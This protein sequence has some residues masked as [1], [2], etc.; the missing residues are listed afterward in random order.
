MKTK[1][2]IYMGLFAAALIFAVAF[3][4][5]GYAKENDDFVIKNG[6]LTDYVGTESKITIPTSV[7][8]IGMRAFSDNS[9]IE[10]VIIPGGVK[11]ID[12]YAFLRCQ[13]LKTVTMKSGVETIEVEAFSGDVNL[14]KVTIPKTVAR[15]KAGNFQD[16]KWLKND[17]R[18]FMIEGIGILIHYSGKS[19]KVTLPS[20]VKGI[21]SDAFSGVKDKLTQVVMNRGLKKISDYAFYGYSK[22]KTVSIPSSVNY[23][24]LD[25]F[26]NTPWLKNNKKEFLV[27]G[28]GILLEYIGSRT[29]AVL[30]TNIKTIY[31][32]AFSN[33]KKLTEVVLNKNLTEIKDAAFFNCKNLKKIN[34]PS[35]VKTIGIDAFS[36]TG[37][38]SVNIPS[39]TTTL[40][41]YAFSYCKNLTQ[42]SF[43]K[44]S[45]LAVIERGLF[46]G[47]ESLN[48]VV[49]PSK[50]TELGEEAFSY[51]T[52]LQSVNLPVTLTKLGDKVFWGDKSLTSI[53][54][55]DK[56]I[57]IPSYLFEDCS[58]LVKVSLSDKITTIGYS[59]F[60]NCGKLSDFTLPSSVKSIGSSAFGNCTSLESIKIN[61]NIKELPSKCFDG[62][63]NLGDVEF[64]D[65]NINVVADA[66]TGTKWMNSIPGDFFAIN[67]KLISYKGKGGKVTIP[68]TI[69]TISDYVFSENTDITEVI[70]PSS[71]KHIGY[72]SFQ[73]CSKLKKVVLP[74]EI[75]YIGEYAFSDCPLLE[76]VTIDD[77]GINNVDAVLSSGAFGYCSNLKKVTL[78]NNITDMEGSAFYG[79]SS[80]S[81]IK[82]PDKLRNLGGLAFGQCN[83]L[84]KVSFSGT[85]DSIGSDVFSTTPYYMESKD[86][87]LVLQNVLLKYS[88]S[89]KSV[90]I[91]ETYNIIASKAFSNNNNLEEVKLPN[92]IKSIGMDAFSGCKNL[93]TIQMPSTQFNIGY[94]AFN[95]TEWLSD[96]KNSY[97]ILPNGILIKYQGTD[98]IVTIPDS[99]TE[100]GPGVFEELQIDKVVIPKSVKKIH[101]YDFLY[102]KVKEVDIAEGVEEIEGGAFEECMHLELIRIPDSV[103]KI[104]GNLVFCEEYGMNY[105]IECS[106]GSKAHEY[107]VAHGVR[108]RLR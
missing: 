72:F 23:I 40:G 108:V 6:V 105:I 2:K 35:G 58:S 77:K 88:G 3:P 43:A 52:Q 93:K 76:E 48:K 47:C 73:H 86:N 89:D 85:L 84:A 51:C 95:D 15:I 18:L 63:T 9:R 8:E 70:L 32:S 90:T 13:N 92:G 49:L 100:I 12:Q 10:E 11:V 101:S 97:V 7:K 34:I 29:K 57:E 28:D 71:V 74:N 25:T 5:K 39:K 81:E 87:I 50:L 21:G 99:V 26:T 41:R 59:A 31:E 37:L 30:P 106:I 20:S 103:N 69:D 79:C 14:S 107:A 56:I 1:Q 61:S 94:G 80:L 67:G 44:D 96:Q 78:P 75:E 27:V 66:L 24:G 55:P 19:T 60:N 16:S 102:S 33:N 83:S 46:T 82:L 45:K 54:I 68:D 65:K 62:C 91:P 38:I 17:K 53:N 98:K 4:V 22:L 104:G 36:N 42:V 64:A